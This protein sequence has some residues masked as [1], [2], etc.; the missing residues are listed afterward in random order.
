MASSTF[1]QGREKLSSFNMPNANLR[2][3]FWEIQKAEYFD[4][5]LAGLSIQDLEK[6]TIQFENQM[7][8][9][10]I[11]EKCDC[12]CHKVFLH[13]LCEEYSNQSKLQLINFD[14]FAGFSNDQIKDH[15]YGR[16]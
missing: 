13:E 6:T 11:G 14:K 1:R 3:L 9:I 2:E 7:K 4:S 5:V 12:W 15:D 8:E 16:S 10:L